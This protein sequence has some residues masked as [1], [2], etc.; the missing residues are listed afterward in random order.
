[1]CDLEIRLRYSMGVS[2]LDLNFKLFYLLYK[3]EMF[4]RGLNL[5]EVFGSSFSFLQNSL[6]ITFLN[7]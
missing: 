7:K 2:L 4:I 3:L 1:M 6:I 5:P